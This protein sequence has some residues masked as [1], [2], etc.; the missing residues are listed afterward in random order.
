MSF[1]Y[2]KDQQPP[3]MHRYTSRCMHSMGCDTRYWFTCKGLTNACIHLCNV[4]KPLNACKQFTHTYNGHTG[5][6]ADNVHTYLEDTCTARACSVHYTWH[7]PSNCL[8]SRHAYRQV[9]FMEGPVVKY[10]RC[11]HVSKHGCHIHGYLAKLGYFENSVT[12]ENVLVAVGGIL[13]YL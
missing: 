5:C 9:L 12:G 7:M 1:P 8:I 13:G 4:I 2:L 3:L 10:Y 6:C 11:P